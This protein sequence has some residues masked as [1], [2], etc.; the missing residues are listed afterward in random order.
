MKEYRIWKSMKSRC[1]SKC[2][3]NT[4]YQ[5]DNIKVCDSWIN[6]FENFLKDMG[7]I[8]SENHSIERKDI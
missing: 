6:S 1:N 5:K 2:N 8:P 3:K 7:N 4:H